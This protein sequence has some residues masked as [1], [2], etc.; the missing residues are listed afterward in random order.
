MRSS[1]P[2]TAVVTGSTRGIGNAIARALVTEGW[3]V[4]VNGRGETAVDSAVAALGSSAHPVPFD[5]TDAAATHG[6]LVAFAKAH[7][8]LDAVIH[9]AGIMKDAPV[10][11]MSDA[12]VR[13]VLDANVVGSINVLQPAMRL[14]TRQRK[15][16]IVLFSS[17]VGSDGA[18]GQ[19][20]YG[21]S[22]AAVTGIVRSASKEAASSG[23]RDNAIE[24]GIIRTVLLAGFSG[25]KFEQLRV[26][27]PLARLGEPD[28]V[29]GLAVFLASDASSYITG[30]T[31]RVDGGLS[32]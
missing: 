28:D 20:I 7:G 21:A 32:L 5:I 16:S 12:L 15:G 23:L 14:M 19:I 9:C 2:G 6:A 17:I 1:N 10:G 26:D 18:S 4:G 29:A 13:E 8:G 30:Q 22:K 3:V 11:M 27:V 24:P 25:E 31:I